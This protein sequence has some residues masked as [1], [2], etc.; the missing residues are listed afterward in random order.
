MKI[1]SDV[2]KCCFAD[3]TFKCFATTIYCRKRLTVK[4]IDAKDSNL[5]LTTKLT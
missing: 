3:T 1:N 2:K 5:L 4:I